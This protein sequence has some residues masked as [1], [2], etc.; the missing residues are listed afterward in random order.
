MWKQINSLKQ[1]SL[2]VNNNYNYL[3]SEPIVC[4]Q[5]YELIIK[6]FILI[7]FQIY[8]IFFIN[9]YILAL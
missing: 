3:L 5:I 1:K 2:K 6:E 4:L 8:I 9:Y 7:K